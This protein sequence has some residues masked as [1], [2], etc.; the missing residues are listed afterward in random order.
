[1]RRNVKFNLLISGMVGIGLAIFFL[2]TEGDYLKAY[3][4]FI[5]GFAVNLMLDI[6]IDWISQNRRKEKQ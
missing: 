4:G 3:V 5:L 2:I 1:M 6:F